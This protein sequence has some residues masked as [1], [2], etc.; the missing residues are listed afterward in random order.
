MFLL[1]SKQ[2]FDDAIPRC[3]FGMLRVV[4]KNIYFEVHCSLNSNGKMQWSMV[5]CPETRTIACA[6]VHTSAKS[7]IRAKNHPCQHHYQACNR[8]CQIGTS[9]SQ[10]QTPVTVIFCFHD[11]AALSCF[12]LN[13]T[14]DMLQQQKAQYFGHKNLG[15]HVQLQLQ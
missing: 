3:C 6:R 8:T 9:L 12:I 5:S 15:S 11:S 7:Q 10:L 2:C 1:F 13:E 14:V 4:P